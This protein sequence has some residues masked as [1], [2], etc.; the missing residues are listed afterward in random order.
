MMIV[1]VKL[2]YTPDALAYSRALL[3]RTANIRLL[4][5]AIEMFAWKNSFEQ[6]QMVRQP[7]LKRTFSGEDSEKQSPK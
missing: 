7:G 3:G 2:A 5:E 4:L 1:I 6:M